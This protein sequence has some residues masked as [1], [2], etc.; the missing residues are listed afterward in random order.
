MN[1]C[2]VPHLLAMVVDAVMNMSSVKSLLVFLLGIYPKVEFLHPR[3]ILFLIAILFFTALHHFLFPPSKAQ[4]FY[5]LNIFA[6]Q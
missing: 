5:F 2:V 4:G 6:R 3:V 1:I